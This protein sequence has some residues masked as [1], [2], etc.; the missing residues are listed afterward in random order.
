MVLVAISVTTAIAVALTVWRETVRYAETKRG[1]LLAVATVFA[2]AANEAVAS[3]NRGMALASLKAIR[4]FPS[5]QYARV[6]TGSGHILAEIG[7]GI[8]LESAAREAAGGS[9][10]SLLTDHALPVRVPVVH[11]GEQIGALVLIATTDDL[12]GR[13]LSGVKTILA[14]AFASGLIGFGAALRL[15]RRIVRPLHRVIETIN[16]IRQSEDFSGRVEQAEDEETARLVDSFNAMMSEINERDVRLARHRETLEIT[17]EERTHELRVAK[18]AAETANA[19][20]SDF[21]ATMSHEIR[22]PMNGMLVM[23]ELLTKARLN[24][25]DHRYAEIILKS[26]K[27]LIAIIND[28]LDLSKIE[29]GRLQLEHTDVAPAGLAADIVDLFWD[30]AAG[31]GLDLAAYVAPGVPAGIFADPVRLHQILSNLVNNAIKFTETGSVLIEIYARPGRGAS[32]WLDVGVTDTGI[33]IPEDR[34][35]T[36]FEMFAQADQTTTR[37]F[38]G[39]GL[40]L[41]I[42]RKLVHAMGGRIGVKSKEGKGSTFHFSVPVDIDRAAANPAP[43]E[44]VNFGRVVIAT[45]YGRTAQTLARTLGDFGLSATIQEAAAVT[46]MR[47]GDGDILIAD[48]AAIDRGGFTGQPRAVV[49]LS[50][51]GDRLPDQLLNDGKATNRLPCPATRDGI[52]GCLTRIAAGVKERANSQT[53]RIDDETLPQFAGARV[54]VADDNAVNRETILAALSR[55]GITPDLVENGQEAVEAVAAGD[56]HFVFMDCSMPVMDGFTAT[57][58]I[59]AVEAAGASGAVKLPIVALTARVLGEDDNAWREAGMDAFLVKPFTLKQI[60]EC[61]SGWLKAF[62]TEAEPVAEP[63]G[64]TAAG[65]RQPPTAAGENAGADDE[66]PL[67]DLSVLES[68]GAMGGVG[69]SSL[70]DRL[71]ALYRANMPNSIAE[72]ERAVAAG[73]NAETERIAHAMKSMSFNIGARRVADLCAGAERAARSGKVSAVDVAAISGEYDVVI[74]AIEE[75]AEAA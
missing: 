43:P 9:V 70:L 45:N 24:D 21:L 73:D 69:G 32:V 18:E 16:G 58:T 20:K 12:F 33:G 15:Q 50:P 4:G 67:L 72:L 31:K 44:A 53:R 34:Q 64:D 22:T 46:G 17:V 7:T 27:S 59:R 23:A 28:I 66:V 5:I 57:R 30:R 1:E 42:C 51:A 35:E 55:F 71:F 41:A 8:V 25:Q 29:A 63:A 11:S 52:V 26:G 38:G 36:V 61:L 65:V 54:L 47:L 60:G 48:P 19:A 68:I 3:E 62:E 2:T 49:V 13:I 40:G 74:A 39:T 56:Y 37:R 6:E 75:L 14:A 10:W